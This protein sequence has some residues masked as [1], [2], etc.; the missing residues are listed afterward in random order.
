MK[1]L[2]D[3]TEAEDIVQDV[4]LEVFRCI[5]SWEGRSALLTWM[6]GIAHHQLCRRFRKKTPISVPMEQIE[7][8]P[9][10]TPEASSDRRVEAS[11]AL[12]VHSR[13]RLPQ[14]MRR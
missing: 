11:R 2:G 3:S 12:G 13:M 5:A 14:S 4:F 10:A 9:P 7:A 8:A 6:F 1:R